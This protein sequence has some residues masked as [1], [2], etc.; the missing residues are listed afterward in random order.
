MATFDAHQISLAMQTTASVPSYDVFEVSFG[1]SSTPPTIENITPAAS[2]QLASK[3]TPIQFD[4]IDS[5]PA[6][7]FA[8]IFVE[9][10]NSGRNEVVHNGVSFEPLFV[11]RSTKTLIAGSANQP[12]G[13]RFSILPAGGWRSNFTLKVRAGDW[14]GNVTLF[15]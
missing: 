6:I 8:I 5:S 9:F 10:N 13:Y 12:T 7:R 15:V 14:H 4:L 11:G 2:T 3:S 1:G